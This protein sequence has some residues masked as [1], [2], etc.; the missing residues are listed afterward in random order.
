L[1]HAAW[2]CMTLMEYERNG[3]GTDDRVPYVLDLMD[4]AE[5]NR[6]IDLW[7]KLAGQGKE[8]EYNGLDVSEIK[9]NKK[10]KKIKK[11]KK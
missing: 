8:E 2:N 4:K 1:A 6:R 10:N 11:E 7:K 5:R 9:I 3:L